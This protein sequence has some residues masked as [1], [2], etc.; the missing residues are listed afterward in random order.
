MITYLPPFLL[1]LENMGRLGCGTTYIFIDC[2]PLCQL[3]FNA[4]ALEYIVTVAGEEGSAAVNEPAE[5]GATALHYAVSGQHEECV[6]VLLQYGADINSLTST[7]EV[8]KCATVEPHILV[9]VND[10]VN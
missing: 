7:E 6:R 8:R 2:H 5:G 9:H 4:A 1:R 3:I 10:F